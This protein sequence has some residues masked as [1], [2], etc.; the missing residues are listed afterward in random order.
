MSSRSMVLPGNRQRLLFTGGE[1]ILPERAYYNSQHRCL[2]GGA[3]TPMFFLHLWI[4]RQMQRCL[5]K[6]DSEIEALSPRMQE[7]QKSFCSA[8]CK[9]VS[10]V[11]PF[12]EIHRFHQCQC[13]PRR[14]VPRLC[15]V[16]IQRQA[17]ACPAA[18]MQYIC[19]TNISSA[20]PGQTPSWDKRSQ[21]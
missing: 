1:H 9:A 17:P 19:R 18:Q 8:S 6:D 12:A 14:S 20:V 15:C 10:G 7:G 11:A 2:A 4:D 16:P 5:K 13:N 21:Q 3:P